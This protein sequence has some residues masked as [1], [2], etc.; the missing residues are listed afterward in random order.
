MSV[1]N[2]YDTNYVYGDGEIPNNIMLIGEAPGEDEDRAGK[3]FVGQAGKLLA[4]LLEE[5]SFLR[6]KD[7]YIT[8]AVKQRPPLNRRPKFLEIQKHRKFL[9]AEIETVKPKVIMTLGNTALQSLFKVELPMSLTGMRNKTFKFKG[10]PIIASYHPAAL[11]RSR[12]YLEPLIEDFKK[13]RQYQGANKNE[14]RRTK[15]ISK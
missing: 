11:F 9:L 1:P 4:K 6:R 5:H 12:I 7:I 8:N 15:S 13:L 14:N 3:P 10:I 2:L